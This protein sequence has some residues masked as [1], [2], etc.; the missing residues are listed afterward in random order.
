MNLD[1]ASGGDI[2]PQRYWFESE[3]TQVGV[4]HSQPHLTPP[5]VGGKF[6]LSSLQSP[7]WGLILRHCELCLRLSLRAADNEGRSS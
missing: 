5:N 4:T 2:E 3:L 7:H 6:L 1:D